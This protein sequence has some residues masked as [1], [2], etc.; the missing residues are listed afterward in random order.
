MRKIKVLI[1]GTPA[2]STLL[3]Y[4]FDTRPEFRV[5]GSYSKAQDLEVAAARVLPE[6]I[7]ASVKPVTTPAGAVAPSIKRSSPDSKLILIFPF[8]ELNGLARKSGADA[9]LVQES[10]VLG[11]IPAATGLSARNRRSTAKK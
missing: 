1:G 6:L 3:R 8:R 11:L 5:V 9:C 4:L 7:V 10:L 2:F